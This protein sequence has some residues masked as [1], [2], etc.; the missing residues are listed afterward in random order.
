MILIGFIWYPIRCIFHQQAA[1]Q[2]RA[3]MCIRQDSKAKMST[4][5]LT[6]SW[7]NSNW[8][9]TLQCKLQPLRKCLLWSDLQYSECIHFLYVIPVGMAFAS[10]TLLP[11]EPHRIIYPPH[12]HLTVWVFF[13]QVF[14]LWYPVPSGLAVCERGSDVSAGGDPERPC[15]GRHR[16]CVWSGIPPLPWRWVF[17]PYQG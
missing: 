7:R 17:T 11:T 13:L 14:R 6:T 15:G 16:S 8:H 12:Y 10:S 2:E 9:Q 5:I 3:A 1:N 4:L